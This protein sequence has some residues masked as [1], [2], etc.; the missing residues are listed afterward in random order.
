MKKTLKRLL[1]FILSCTLFLGTMPMQ[2]F[3]AER[4]EVYL[5]ENELGSDILDY[6]VFYLATS[7]ALIPEGGNGV[8]LLRIGRGGP[9][10]SESTALIKIAD[11]TAKY[12]ED[13]VV[14]VHDER[15]KVEDPDDNF[16]LLELIEGSDFE[17]GELGSEE[18]FSEIL[19]ND[20]EAQEAYREGTE[21]ALEFLN[22]A[23][24]LK[25]KYEEDNPYSEALE[26]LY[27]END[28][29]SEETEPAEEAEAVEDVEPAAEAEAA[30]DAEPA[31]EVELSEEADTAADDDDSDWDEGAIPAIENGEMISIGGNS[32]DASERL[33]QAVNLFTGQNAAA[34]RLTAE[35]DMFQDLQ[36]IANVMTNL[37]VGASVE[38]TFAPGET[39]KYLEIVPKDNRTGDGDRMFYI[40]L[41]APS[42]STTNSSASTC[43]FTIVDDEEQEPA[44]VSFSKAVYNAGSGSVT[45]TVERSGAMNTVI[46]AGVRTTGEGTAQAGRDYSE[47]DTELVFPFGVDHL[48]VTIPVR[49]EY[50]TGRGSFELDLEPLAGCEAGEYDSAT[51]YLY[52]DYLGKASLYKAQPT[53]LQNSLSGAPLLA[54]DSG[55]GSSD[56]AKDVNTLQNV[57]TGDSIGINSW[58]DLAFT[59]DIPNFTGN[60]RWR[61]DWNG[62]LLE[63]INSADREGALGVSWRLWESGYYWVSGFQMDW[64]HGGAHSGDTAWAMV[65][66]T[67]NDSNRWDDL[68]VH[69][70]K[71]NW[72]WYSFSSS[73]RFESTTANFYLNK[74]QFDNWNGEAPYRITI[75]NKG[76]CDDCDPICIYDIQP[77]LRPFQINLMETDSLLYLKADGSREKITDASTTAASIVGADSLP[78]FYAGDEFTVSTPTYSNVDVYGYLKDINWVDSNGNKL[79][80]LASITDQTAG[81]IKVTLSKDVINSM[82][83]TNTEQF[84]AM[85]RQ[86]P[87]EKDTAGHINY[88]Y[89]NYALMNI[90]AELGYIDA[91]VTLRNP[92]DFPVTMTISGTE[93]ALAAKE[94]RKIKAPDGQEFHLGDTLSATKIELGAASSGHYTPIGI[95]YWAIDKK[96]NLV[97]GTIN[98]SG[99]NAANFSGF[100]GDGRL[101]TKEIIV[102]PNLQQD[103]NQIVVRVKTDELAKFDTTKSAG[104]LAQKGTVDGDYT[105][106]VY[107][108][109][110]KTMNGKL[111][112]ITVTPLSEDTVATWYDGVALRTYVGNTLYFTAGNSASRNI[113]TLSAAPA[114]GSVTLEGTLKYS[115]YNMRSKFSGNA[116]NVPAAGAILSAG[117]AGGVANSAG[118]ISA[119]PIPITGQADQYLRYIVSVNGVD[120]VKELLLPETVSD[121]DLVE[122]AILCDFNSDLAMD[123]YMG[124]HG[125][126]SLD[127]TGEKDSA[128]NDYYSFTATGFSPRVSLDNV[129]ANRLSEIQWVKMRVRNV[130]G[131]SQIRFLFGFSDSN[132]AS[133]SSDAYLT[134]EQDT[135]WHEYLFNYRTLNANTGHGNPGWS[136]VS[137]KWMRLEPMLAS[138]VKPGDQI[139]IDYIAFFPDEA[140]VNSYVYKAKPDGKIDISS[141]FQDGINP[142]ASEIFQDIS[143]TGTMSGGYQINNNT[144]IPSV[145]GQSA[146]MTVAIKPKRYDYTTTGKDGQTIDDYLIEAP[147]A[148]QFV[149]YD[150]NDVY[151]GIYDAVN[152]PQI[153][154][155]DKG[156][157]I[158]SF[159]SRMDF[160]EPM[161]CMELTDEDGNPVLDENS[162]PIYVAIDADGNPQKDENGDYVIVQPG[163]GLIPSAGDKLYLRLTTNR[164]AQTSD[165]ANPDGVP[166]YKEYIYSDVF[167]GMSFVQPTT[168]E[169]PLQMNL[170]MPVD[171]EYGD[172]PFV[173]STGMNLAFPFVTLGIMRIY[174]GY[175]IYF[176]VSPIQIMDSIKGTHLSSMSGAGGD[177]WES[178]FS[179]GHPIDTFMDDITSAANVVDLY[180]EAALDAKANDES[181]SAMSLGSPSWK[182]DLSIGMYFDFVAA[183]VTQGEYTETDMIFNGLGGYVSVSL[184]FSMAWYIILP[185][186][187]IPGYLGIE[188]NGTILGFLGANFNKDVQISYDSLQGHTS[189]KEGVTELEG[190]IRGLGSVQISLG[191]GL[192]GTLGVRLSGNVDMIA[193]W[194]PGD[195]HGDWGFYVTLSVGGI[196]DLF[197]FSIPLMFEVGGWPFGSFE[198]YANNTDSETVHSNSLLN[199]PLLSASPASLQSGTLK[200]RE[201]SGEDSMWLGDQMMVQG[202]FRPNKD[203]QQILAV[204]AY[205]H[206]DSQLITLADGE[207]LALAFIDSDSRKDV[208]QRTTLKLSIYDADTGIWSAPVPVAADNTADFQ[209]SIAQMKD[210]RLLVAW[211][212]TSDDSI[213]D[214]STDEKAMAYLESMD[215]YAAFIELDG[216]AI[217]TTTVDGE[218]VAD[219]EVTLL[220]H[221]N[222][223][224]ATDGA[225]V[226]GYYDANPTVVCDMETGDAIVYYI[227]SDRVYTQDH[228]DGESIGEYINP[229]TNDSVVSYMLYSSDGVLVTKNGMTKTEHWLFDYYYDGEID[230]SGMDD[231]MIEAF[232]KMLFEG[233]GGQRFLDGPISDTN[234]RY[235]IPDFTAIGYDGLAV[236]AYTV[237]PDGSSD[238]DADKELYLQVYDFN[239]HKTKYQTV[240]TSDDVADTL[241]QLFH[242]RVNT[243]SGEEA[244]TKLF[245]YRDG[246][247]VV[248]IDVTELLEKGL[249]AN[250]TL[251]Q[252]AD[253]STYYTYTD[254]EGVQHTAPD[255]RYYIYTDSN[256]MTHSRFTD[257]Q[258]V[259]FYADD[260]HA[261]LQSADF[262]AVE[263]SLG[264]LYILWTEGVTDEDGNTAR[265]IFGTGLVSYEHSYVD[266][267]GRSVT[268]LESTGWS[269]PYQI[270]DDGF[271]N[272]ELAAAMS[273]ENLVVVH[274]RYSE[275]LNR[276]SED[277]ATKG[278]PST[279]SGETTE[280]PLI[281]SDMALVADTLEPCGSVETERI[282]LYGA[283][284]AELILPKSGDTIFIEATVANNGMNTAEGYKLSLYAGDELIDEIVTTEALIPNCNRTHT[285]RYTM[286][287]SVDGLVF[288][289]VAQEMKDSATMLY[290]NDRDTFLADPLEARADY[291]ITNV[292]TYQTVDGFHAAFTVTNTG[293][294]ASSGD[295][296]LNVKMR[297][298]ADLGDLYTDALYDSTISLAV[299]ESK[300][301]DIPV[302]ISS[303]MM[304]DYGFV[305]TLITV[306]KEVM[307]GSGLKSTRY[308]SNMVYADFDLSAPMDME[309]QDVS[310]EIDNGADIA[311]AMSL[312][313]RFGSGSASVTYAVDDL[314]VARVENG[315]VIGV[316]N[317]ETVLHATHTATG[318]TV[319]A[320]VTVT[321]ERES[322]DIELTSDS[323][324]LN[325]GASDVISYT[326]PH[327]GTV[328]FT[329][330]NPAVATVDANGRVRAIGAG[331]AIITVTLT[332]ATGKTYTTACTVTV[333]NSTPT[334]AAPS[335]SDTSAQTS[336]EDSPCDRGESCP[337][338]AFSDLDRKL[339]YHDGVHWALENGIMSGYTD[340]TFGPNDAISR[341]MI[342]SMLYRIEGKPAADHDMSF[343]DVEEGKWYTEAIRWAAS[344]G[345]VAGYNDESFGPNDVLT[346]EQL[347]AILYRYA[348]LKGQG[349]TGMW[350][351]PLNFDDASE[352]SSW[353]YEAMCWMTMNG[354]IMGTGNNKLSPKG[355]AT[356][357][358]VANMLKRYEVIEQ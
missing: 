137:P 123:A 344:K 157:T 208:T 309:L 274:N 1:C 356:R 272:D 13:Y 88:G 283:D 202:A 151:R 270:T 336:G 267:N 47:V 94:T 237:D 139:Q 250:G 265:E 29:A 59:Q 310:V 5:P 172:L 325:K 193:N 11:M 195:P 209:P 142:A 199:A 327:E 100:D 238:T 48:S 225:K 282:R 153:S 342:V 133:G 252:R 349:F 64:M 7:G 232:Y 176:G 44:V 18:E 37:V 279:Y 14:R 268:D 134:L 90:R 91:S 200:L 179:L 308:L 290:Y 352:V 201:G 80:T 253:G 263:D 319:T 138:E 72:N 24:G 312:G 115:N 206:G 332:D 50:L 329:S 147:L 317:G 63:W 213:T 276:P 285:F 216:K 295:D 197:L 175:R 26:E 273:G 334:P 70:A 105:Y 17:Q 156:N 321:G 255:T 306:Q 264:R 226:Q 23:S 8:Y 161:E 243:G 190:A 300:D 174:H 126:G 223:N 96:G 266:E 154:A 66:V 222:F 203:K 239:R 93:Y 131:V 56:V 102:E 99:K 246:K 177:Y 297:G 180:R 218:I 97:D 324:D 173:G 345:I 162:E 358:Q 34:Q 233:F 143:I 187:F 146:T 150:Q 160:A 109:N 284:G 221:D 242:S 257:P 326:S 32:D 231:E 288:R 235:A 20:P 30:E 51:V 106:F 207:T 4:T 320:T 247:Q 101:C 348:K 113:I 118:F 333:K 335:D 182:F 277:T 303:E 215:V 124:G 194:E 120:V 42:G 136:T 58:K 171:I 119:G 49:T 262:Q 77:I 21:T 353:A 184:G 258:V 140:S 293:N 347:A 92:Y 244:H 135:E 214:V 354:V 73:A 25:D 236:C 261:A 103:D 155:D 125:K 287:E 60:N 98:F 318:A 82:G 224:Y 111:Y 330:N 53:R 158:Y 10:D 212:S 39:E 43:A 2:V 85:L 230:T 108:D 170:D 280:S 291:K 331:T 67:G 78:V 74:A 271:H 315:R 241:P 205:E 351:F 128:G 260:S 81:A 116:S 229:Y 314:T 188:L 192:C 275:E 75:Y 289:V 28:E 251:K 343:K 117:S 6:D 36:S 107:A 294:A 346:R 9:A 211:V 301:F 110:S 132:T 86:V 298:P 159:R 313:D 269:Q 45:V 228:Q 152:D 168:K 198:Y 149:V 31:E 299:D 89:A 46:S 169:V 181:F 322:D 52:G 307:E 234:E 338:S 55:A 220:T 130:T 254:E 350:A 196:I 219:T 341:A 129:S 256:G 185:V 57:E 281:I 15:T 248:Y 302:S 167:T 62:Y 286:P 191:V 166:T 145:T 183:N 328:T 114:A 305:T 61:S 240:L 340:G 259:Y 339:W 189:V 40:I 112:P 122:P 95:S 204:N 76:S 83:N 104:L 311:F 121:A 296:T 33:R 35:G 227:K 68:S 69:Q 163:M 178:S 16:S 337:M 38:L 165:L 87:Y 127:I 141:N 12:D 316:G 65:E 186:V 54:A 27:S 71:G 41:G 79:L 292:S 84:K 304:E 245:W 148:I 164:L 278:D 355:S 19:E 144:F 357:A 210:G 323:M 3:A 249:N 217:K 22:N